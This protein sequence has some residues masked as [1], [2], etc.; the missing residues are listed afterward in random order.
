MTAEN[1]TET[2]ADD[3]R[4]D[5]RGSGRSGRTHRYAA[6]DEAKIAKNTLIV[7]VS[8]N[9]GFAG[10]AHMGPLRGA[11]S[12]TW[13][14]GIRVPLIIRWPDKIKPRTVSTQVCATFDLTRSF[15]QLTGAK[16]SQLT[17]DGYDI[18]GHVTEDRP[19]VSRT[20]FWRGRRG[21]RTWTAVRHGDLKFV[22]K[23]EGKQTEEWLFDLSQDVG[24]QHD[25]FTKQP[26]DAAVLWDMLDDWQ[27]TI[28]PARPAS[29]IPQE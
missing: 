12:S 4:I 21:E 22:A 11:K 8:D 19:D 13:E 2:D 28:R 17:L 15:L 18:I 26:E 1:W 24:E 9:G 3:V 10:A 14:G 6:V 7:F 20:L 23:R 27:R 16:V 29:Y 25:L 5:A